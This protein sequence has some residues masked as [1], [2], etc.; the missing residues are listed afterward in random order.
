M[1]MLMMLMLLLEELRL[2]DG[3]LV[4][5]RQALLE[6]KVLSPHVV[7]VVVVVADAERLAVD[8]SA[9]HE[10]KTVYSAKSHSPANA[11]G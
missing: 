10:N 4:R 6:L 5:E 9:V 7:V 8:V 1:L 3:L 2:V 11:D